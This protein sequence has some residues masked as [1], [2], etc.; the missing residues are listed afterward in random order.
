[1]YKE[2]I[3]EFKQRRTNTILGDKLKFARGSYGGFKVETR[4]FE[5][6]RCIILIFI[7]PEP[8]KWIQI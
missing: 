7:L 4:K 1:M 3:I 6:V 5:S 2:K 8:Y